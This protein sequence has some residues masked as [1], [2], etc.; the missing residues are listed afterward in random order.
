MTLVIWSYVNTNCSAY[1]LVYIISIP[2]EE[3]F[4]ETTVGS[5]AS[6]F[7]KIILCSR[8]FCNPP[9]FKAVYCCICGRRRVAV[10]RYR[11]ICLVLCNPLIIYS[12]AFPNKIWPTFVVPTTQRWTLDLH[13]ACRERGLPRIFFKL[14]ETFSSRPLIAG[15]INQCQSYE[16]YCEQNIQT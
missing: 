9:Y 10:A 14:F 15:P 11:M 12:Q 3:L 5:T 1:C 8:W 6:Y 2:D 7:V 16:Q 4:S 13:T